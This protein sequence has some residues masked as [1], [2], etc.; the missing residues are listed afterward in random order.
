MQE[1]Y[2]K[3]KVNLSEYDLKKDSLL[4]FENSF[5]RSSGFI[6]G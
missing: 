3:I 2:L 4:D 5:S 1:I 6:T